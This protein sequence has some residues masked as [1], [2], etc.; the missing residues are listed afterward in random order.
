MCHHDTAGLGILRWGMNLFTGLWLTNAVLGSAAPR[1]RATANQSKGIVKP[2]RKTLPPPG[3]TPSF[4]LSG[5]ALQPETP[6]TGN[7]SQH[8]PQSSKQNPT[9]GLAH[10]KS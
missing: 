1:L 6:K 8:Q 7:L 3:E 9:G 5:S 10:E 2:C 4:T